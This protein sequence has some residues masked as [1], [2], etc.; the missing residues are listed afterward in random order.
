MRDAPFPDDE[1]GFAA[2]GEGFA[3]DALVLTDGGERPALTLR[4]G[5]RI[6][7]RDGG[8]L[9]LLGLQP[10]AAAGEL[11]QVWLRMAAGVLGAGRDLHLGAGQ[12]LLLDHWLIRPLFGCSQALIRCGHLLNGSG[13]ALAEPPGA[14]PMVR[15]RLAAEALIRVNG[16]WICGH[17]D[18]PPPMRELTGDD[19]DAVGSSGIFVRRPG[20]G[21]RVPPRRGSGRMLL[22]AIGN[23]QAAG[24]APV[25]GMSGPAA[26]GSVSAPPGVGGVCDG[27]GGA[28]EEGAEDARPGDPRTS[29]LPRTGTG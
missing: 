22:Q 14:A 17:G 6:V 28:A 19:A 10:C 8:A 29:A 15:L 27:P 3:G 16:M 24:F 13:V 20:E 9:P 23:R 25:A 5:D 21:A 4:P 7:T 2:V 1:P 12:L 18:G 26:D 11:P